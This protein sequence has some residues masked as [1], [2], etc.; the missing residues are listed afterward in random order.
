MTCPK[1]VPRLIALAL[2]GAFLVV[3]PSPAA[4]G[5]SCSANPPGKPLEV[6]GRHGGPNDHAFIGS[7]RSIGD[8]PV[9]AGRK[10]GGPDYEPGRYVP[11]VL[12]VE[13]KLAGKIPDRAIVLQ[14]APE[15][16]AI[17]TC[18]FKFSEGVRYLV[19]A[20]KTSDGTF[21]TDICTFTQVYGSAAEPPADDT[22]GDEAAGGSVAPILVLALLAVGAGAILRMT[23]RQRET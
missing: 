20:R 16:K 14:Q 8:E 17:D 12:D 19:E 5:C 15:A 22:G 7:V 18:A 9:K 13:V 21:L 2:L 3:A 4:F 10:D 6:A 11:V 1:S 23:F